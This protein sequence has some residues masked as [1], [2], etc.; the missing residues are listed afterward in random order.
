[1][2]A[3]L[4]GTESRRALRQLLAML[5]DDEGA[6]VVVMEDAIDDARFIVIHRIRTHQCI[7]QPV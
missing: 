5:A 2:I 1:M 7:Q 6:I 4:P 3:Y